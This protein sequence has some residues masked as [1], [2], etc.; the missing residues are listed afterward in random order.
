M[1]V[2]DRSYGQGLR[3]DLVAQAYVERPGREYVNRHAKQ[4]SQLVA[5]LSNVEDGRFGCGIDQNIEIASLGIVPAQYRSEDTGIAGAAR[6][7]DAAN[8][9]AVQV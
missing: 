3:D 5:N 4:R 1:R 7:D 6:L 9:L 2:F 8:L